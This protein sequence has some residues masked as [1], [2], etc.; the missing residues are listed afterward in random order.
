MSE[1]DTAGTL[2]TSAPTSTPLRSLPSNE[3]TTSLNEGAPSLSVIDLSNV[4][5]SGNHDTT[6][7]THRTRPRGHSTSSVR[8]LEPLMAAPSLAST[9]SSIMSLPM[10]TRNLPIERVV[11]EPLAPSL[12][13][14]RR[15]HP[16]VS[17]PSLP[18]SAASTVSVSS[19]H[20][21]FRSSSDKPRSRSRAVSSSSR[22]RSASKGEGRGRGRSKSP[23]WSLWP[24]SGHRTPSSI[25]SDDV[26][27][28]E[29]DD[30]VEQEDEGEGVAERSP[31]YWP[32][33]SR[34]WR[35]HS[36]RFWAERGREKRKESMSAEQFQWL[37]RIKEASFVIS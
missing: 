2:S 1:Q 18:P 6:K 4:S 8:G 23:S 26:V 31:D 9:T 32:T 7:S 15:S 29:D 12:S 13:S 5:S 33:R 11:S 16:Q 24:R 22:D 28:L 19:A 27:R 21:M 10:P 14:N 20:Q 34:W 35:T 17:F 25:V 37:L 36:P 3:S 30:V